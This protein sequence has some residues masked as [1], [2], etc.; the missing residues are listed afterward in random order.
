MTTLVAVAFPHETTA[1]AAAEDVQQVASDIIIEPDAIAVV[2]RDEQSRF[3]V[4][5]HHHAVTGSI[6]GVFWILLFSVL[7]FVPLFG[8]T[9]GDDISGLL[10]KI[11]RAGIDNAFQ[12]AIRELLQPGTSALFLAM[13]PTVPA[14][15]VEAL[16]RFGGTVVTSPLP[17]ESERELQRA[18]HGTFALPTT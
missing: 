2:S 17:A 4:T 6:W 15:A 12:Q 5:T 7:F 3:H 16:G 14:E 18:L 10:G 11:Q 1:S 8:M 9:V 13:D